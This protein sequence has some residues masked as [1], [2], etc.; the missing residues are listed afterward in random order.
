M[1]PLEIPTG[2][3]PVSRETLHRLQQYY[4][5]LIKWQEKI[6]LISP[7]T[8]PKAWERHFL[9]SLQIAPLVPKSAK[10]LYD[11]GSGAG[12]PGMILAIACPDIKVTMIESDSKKCAFLQT[13]SR[14]TD[15]P[16]AIQNERIEAIALPAPGVVTARAL[17]PL[18]TLFAYTKDWHQDCTAI[19]LK[20]A[21]W[22][23]EAA[24]ARQSG[25]DF[26]YDA[27][28]SRTEADAAILICRNIRR[29]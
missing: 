2:F 23:E 13:V 17:A 19:F 21:H 24:Q 4:N 27:V 12:F 15:T 28:P 3:P 16:V 26:S 1:T 11:V 20:G 25:W 10:T 6:N 5:L 14:E 22:Q 9:D 7:A 8:I 18:S 29:V